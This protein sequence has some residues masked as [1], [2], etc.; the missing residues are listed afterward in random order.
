MYVPVPPV[1][2]PNAV[3]TVLVVTPVPAMV[4]PTAMVPE[5]TALTVKVVNAIVP[6]K[7]TGSEL[8]V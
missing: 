7:A 4:W 2:V 5:V 3:I 1:P 6:V 8:S